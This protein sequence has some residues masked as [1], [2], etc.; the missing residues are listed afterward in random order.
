MP[1]ILHLRIARLVF[2]ATLAGSSL[3]QLR[4]AES[5][6]IV[7]KVWDDADVSDYRLPLYGLGHPPA[8]LSAREYYALPES[9][10]KTYPVYTPDKEPPGYLD[11]L[12]QQAPQ[13]LVDVGKLKTEAD[14]IAAGREVFYGRE[15]PRF[16]GSE[17]SLQMIR[18]PQVLAAYRLQTTQEGVLLGL[19]YV[20]REKGQVALG[21]DTCAMCHVQVLP[22]GQLIEGAPN[23]TT[24]FG[25]LMADLT[26]RYA[27]MS[28]EVLE[29]R[30]RWHMREDYRVP[31]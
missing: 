4:A 24:P 27:Q 28:P 25:P 3:P 6:G 26:R 31:Y 19:R 1:A 23:V 2:L 7:P 8:L 5:S 10:L 14:W 16:T 29:Q 15:L 12:K 30:R 22:G 21:T 18:N 9:N 11:W 20:V 13:P 17:H